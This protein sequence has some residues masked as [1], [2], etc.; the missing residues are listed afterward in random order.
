[1]KAFR[2]A[3]KTLRVQNG[4]DGLRVR[5]FAAIP[6]HPCRLECLGVCPAA[7]ETWTMA[8]RECGGLIEKK[9]FGPMSGRHDASFP[10][11]EF[12]KADKP[13]LACPRAPYRPGR[14]VVYYAAIADE[15]AAI[16]NRYD[17]TRRRDA[18][19]QG[20]AAA[21]LSIPAIAH[22]R[23]VRTCN[24]P[25]AGRGVQPANHRSG[26]DDAS[27]GSAGVRFP[28]GGFARVGLAKVGLAKVGLARV[29][30]AKVRSRG[31]PSLHLPLLGHAECRS[32]GVPS[33]LP[34]ARRAAS[35]RSGRR[36]ARCGRSCRR[37][38][39]GRRRATR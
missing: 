17:L 38:C 3:G 26:G 7:L 11:F 21:A 35:A 34:P 16:G 29:T 28:R 24:S 25:S 6:T 10:A 1:M 2:A 18:I 5:Q 15:E 23:V 8:G 31:S 32:C 4:I 36:D 20:H 30:L 22:Q 12:A 14:R 37:A 13:A 9:Q 39:P 19:S 33:P 27:F